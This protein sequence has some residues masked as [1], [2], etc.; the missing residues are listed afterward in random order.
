MSFDQIS[1]IL[2][3]CFILFEV[4][5]LTV[6]ISNLRILRRLGDY[7]LPTGWPKVSILVP[8]RNEADNIGPCVRSL[9]QQQYPA[10]EILVLDD[11]STDDTWQHLCALASDDDRLHIRKG[12]P[13]PPG[14]LGK[15]WA[16]HQLAQRAKGELLLFT[17]AD[18]R[19]HPLMLRDSV[20]AIIDEEADL[21]TALPHEETGS[22]G[23]NLVIPILL[24]C[25]MAFV[26][27]GLAYRLRLPA[28]SATIGQFMLF[29]RAA[30]K[31]I[32]GYAS[33]RD[34]VVDDLALG[35]RTKAFGLRWRL[36]DGGQRI[37]CRMYKNFGE[38]FAGLSKNLYAVFGNKPLP[39]LFAWSWITVVFWG[40]FI[41]LGLALS[42]VSL[43]PITLT[44]T[45]LAI[46][47]ALL[48]W[49]LIH[50]RFGFPRYLP[51]LYPVTI[52]LATLIALR[53]MILTRQGQTT[54]KGRVL[55][56]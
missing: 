4:M 38:V 16:C 34:E 42:G 33:I 50:W 19:H 44:L 3:L 35:R 12:D 37:S 2:Q 23:E 51:L 7:P 9:Q 55:A 52:L 26:P 40:P 29:R 32:G 28:L 46:A 11:H 8:A 41:T 24:W 27:L 15:H 49:S 5:V 36:A 6:I 17:D 56:H 25:I 31:K 39:F 45:G 20:A 1:L 30:Y 48:I 10:F 14:W 18:T 53:S 54:W 13:L 22:W 21:L 43:S 47:L